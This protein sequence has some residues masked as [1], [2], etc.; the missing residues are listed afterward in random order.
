MQYRKNA[1]ANVWSYRLRLGE[2]PVIHFENT[3]SRTNVIYRRDQLEC[4]LE[5]TDEENC[6]IPVPRHIMV[7]AL[8]ALN[9]TV[10]AAA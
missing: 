5:N 4:I 1:C 3:T 2:K 8:N 6:F 7:S 9:T 10:S